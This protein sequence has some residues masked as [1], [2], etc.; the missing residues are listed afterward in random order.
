[1]GNDYTARIR[2]ETPAIDSSYPLSTAA[3]YTETKHEQIELDL[4]TQH[5]HAAT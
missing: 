3:V 2:V 1:M 5:T 4:V